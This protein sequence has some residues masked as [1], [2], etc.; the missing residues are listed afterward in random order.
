MVMWHGTK[1][2]A[3]ALLIGLAAAA[4]AQAASFGNPIV[5]E[6]QGALAIGLEVQNVKAEIGDDE[7]ESNRYMVKGTYL[8]M[9]GVSLNLRAGAADIDVVGEVAGNRIPLETN[10][11]FAWGGGVRVE[12]WKAENVRFTPSIVLSA[13]GLMLLSSGDG[14]F[15]LVFPSATLRERFE[16]DYKWREFQGTA[17][18]LF[19]A[20]H[21]TPYVGLALRG[22]DGEVKR[23]QTDISGSTP[24]IVADETEEFGSSISPYVLAGL[25]YRVGPFFRLSVEGFAAGDNDYGFYVGVS[26]AGD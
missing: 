5:I 2:G 3:L 8:A 17:A 20:V 10:P 15:D 21:V 19:H 24:S 13:E 9:P 22:I 12:A 11:R 1:I 25:D 6:K 26:E 7:A 23:V 18:V 14:E 16:A 4:G